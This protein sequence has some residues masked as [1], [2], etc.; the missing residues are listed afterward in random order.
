[1]H[2]RL[3]VI[4]GTQF[5][6]RLEILD[7][8]KVCITFYKHRYRQRIYIAS[9]NLYLRNAEHLQHASHFGRSKRRAEH[10]I[11]LADHIA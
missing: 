9:I 4:P 5:Q 11:Y 1:M 2:Q 8:S 10:F 3:S 7:G 6:N